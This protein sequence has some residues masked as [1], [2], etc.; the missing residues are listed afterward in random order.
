[1]FSLLALALGELVL[2]EIKG[3]GENCKYGNGAL[4]T[5]IHLY[6]NRLGITPTSIRNMTPGTPWAYHAL[7][8]LAL[9]R[10]KQL[11]LVSLG[12]FF[13]MPPRIRA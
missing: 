7:S 1:M 12:H 10:S 11:R 6:G 9:E 3:A 13:R 5:M 4:P 8:C 2:V